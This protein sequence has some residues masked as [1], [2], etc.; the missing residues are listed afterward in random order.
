MSQKEIK[1]TVYGSV[2]LYKA[3]AAAM[4]FLQGE[5]NGTKDNLKYYED[6]ILEDAANDPN[7]KDLDLDDLIEKFP[8]KYDVHKYIQHEQDLEYIKEAMYRL[9]LR[10]G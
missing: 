7:N 4:D 3:M 10:C 2:Y 9:Q 5:L 8:E 6:R 1:V